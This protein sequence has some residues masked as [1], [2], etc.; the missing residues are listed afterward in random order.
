MWGAVPL[1]LVHGG[2]HHLQHEEDMVR[3]HKQPVVTTP[4]YKKGLTKKPPCGGFECLH[5]DSNSGFDLERVASWSP[6][7]W[8][9]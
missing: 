9:Q 6:R 1:L 8:R 3:H 7:R 4:Y 5:G 2:T